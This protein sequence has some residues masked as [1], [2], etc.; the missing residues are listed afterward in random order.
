[1]ETVYGITSPFIYL[2]LR[3]RALLFIG[4]S[5]TSEPG[6]FADPTKW[7]NFSAADLLRLRLSSVTSL[8]QVHPEHSV[9]DSDVRKL[10]EVALSQKHV[11]IE[12]NMT[13]SREKIFRD[14]F[15]GTISVKGTLERVLNY[16]GTE[17]S[18]PIEKAF[19]D[20]NLRAAEAVKYLFESDVNIYK[21]QQLLSVGSLGINRKLV[22]TR[23][24]ITAVDS[25][26]S[27][28]MLRKIIRYGIISNYMVG[29][30]CIMGNRFAVILEPENYSFE[31]LESWAPYNGNENVIQVL[32]RDNE[33][34]FGR[35]D[36]ANEV[37]GAYYAARFSVAQ[38]LQRIMKQASVIVLMEV[39][40]GWIPSLGVWRVR[41]GIRA[42]LDNM[43]R[44]DDRNHAF[45]EAFGYMKTRRESWIISSSKFRQIKMDEFL[46]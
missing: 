17:F 33:G 13:K 34:Y 6:L 18:R 16:S 37:E 28:N 5:I 4:P 3:Y 7:L 35:T 32:A 23:W 36:Y 45:N 10:R 20:N 39:D 30:S 29:K 8:K 31:M 19:S 21:I 12:V 42:A 43:H 2:P 38:F 9:L 26:L 27:S 24:S 44:Q 46:R 11:D 1:M 15:T 22:A 40:R 41:E 25:M 14:Q